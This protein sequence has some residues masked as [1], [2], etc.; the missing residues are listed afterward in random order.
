[1]QISVS[2]Y[3][4]QIYHMTSKD[5]KIAILGNFYG[6]FAS[7]LE[8]EKLQ[9]W[10]YTL[11]KEWLAQFPHRIFFW[12]RMDNFYSEIATIFHK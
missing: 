6:D 11:G 8:A 2:K 7:F 10:F 12:C 5:L 3:I 9:S 4:T 1:M